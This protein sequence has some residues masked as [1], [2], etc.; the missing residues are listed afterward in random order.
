LPKRKK[1]HPLER[2]EKPLKGFLDFLKEKGDKLPEL[3]MYGGT[4]YL[5]YRFAEV[6]GFKL[7]DRWMGIIAGMVGL[8]LATTPSSGSALKI[9]SP[10]FGVDIPFNSQTVGLGILATLG[11]GAAVLPHVKEPAVKLAGYSHPSVGLGEHLR[12]LLPR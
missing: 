11:I 5:G 10:I 8:K 2:L 6:L 4:G 7:Q 9:Y 3:A 12:G 1:K